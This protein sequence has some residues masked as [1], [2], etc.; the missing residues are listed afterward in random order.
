VHFKWLT[1]S[2]Y[3]TYAVTKQ[4]TRISDWLESVMD[5]PTTD[6]GTI[7]RWSLKN[8]IVISK[9]CISSGQRFVTA[10]NGIRTAPFLIQNYRVLMIT[11]H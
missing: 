5:N 1:W 4:E 11:T 2:E 9:D 10:F 6:W 8:R 3:V 7:L